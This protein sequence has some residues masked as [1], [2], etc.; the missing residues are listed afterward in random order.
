MDP[1]FPEKFRTMVHALEVQVASLV[2]SASPIES[3]TYDLAL[4][5]KFDGS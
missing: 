1:E 2:Q 4:P 3:H 5:E